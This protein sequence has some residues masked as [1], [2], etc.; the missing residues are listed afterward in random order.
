MSGTDCGGEQ[1]DGSAD[2]RG[3]HSSETG[4]QRI[5][6]G[7]LIHDRKD[8]LYASQ[9]VEEPPSKGVGTRIRRQS[10]DLIKIGN[11]R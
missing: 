6:T 5:R 8:P 3:L 2:R 1:R 9:V 11:S 7:K 10:D 4:G